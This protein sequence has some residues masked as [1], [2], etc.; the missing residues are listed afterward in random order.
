MP[1][2]TFRPTFASAPE[3]LAELVKTDELELTYAHL[4]S[5]DNFSNMLARSL[6]A[7]GETA[8]EG[9]TASEAAAAEE[10]SE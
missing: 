2:D 5:M 10:A 3:K 1:K 7:T 4:T 9:E 6:K 8:G